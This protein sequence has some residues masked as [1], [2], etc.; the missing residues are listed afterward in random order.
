MTFLDSLNKGYLR[1][2]APHLEISHGL[3]TKI[4]FVIMV[5]IAPF[6]EEVLY[7]KIMLEELLRRYGPTIGI[8]VTS[9]LFAVMH[10]D[11]HGIWAYLL[12]AFALTYV[13]YHT[14]N[15]WFNVFLHFLFNLIARFTRIGE[16]LFDSSFF[17]TGVL[18]YMLSLVGTI[19]VLLKFKSLA[20]KF[21]TTANK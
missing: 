18:L 17:G 13:Y 15:I 3:Y 5:F 20:S 14:R 21:T 11:L 2:L 19:F 16:Y 9:V 12:A 8:T 6:L 7:R 1:I 10:M 4:K